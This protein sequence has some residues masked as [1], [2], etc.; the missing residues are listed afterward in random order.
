MFTWRG[1]PWLLGQYFWSIMMGLPTFFII[2]FRKEMFVTKLLLALAHVL[3][4]TPFWVLLKTE[5]VTVTFWTPSSFADAPRLPM[6][7][8]HKTEFVTVIFQTLTVL[9]DR[10]LKFI[11]GFF[12]FFYTWK[13]MNIVS[14]QILLTTL[15][16]LKNVEKREKEYNSCFV[17]VWINWLTEWELAIYTTNHLA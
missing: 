14:W 6:L 3:I 16:Y 2:R 7:W 13:P 10:W 11:W 5:F 4:R 8:I 9:M 12:F 1:Q 15:K 17:I